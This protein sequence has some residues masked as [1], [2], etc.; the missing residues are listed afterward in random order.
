[1]SRF[2][3]RDDAGRALVGPVAALGLERPVL[4][5]LARG[6]V[7]VAAALAAGLGGAGRGTGGL[8][9]AVAVARKVTRPGAPEA[10]LGAVAAEGEPVWFSAALEQQGLSPDGLVDEVAAAREEVRRREAAWVTDRRDTD[11]RAVVGGR[12]VVLVDDGVA[13]G[14]TAHAALLALATRG[15]RRLVL[16]TPVIAAASRRRLAHEWGGEIVAAAAPE[17]FDAVASSYDDFHQLTD[18]DV[19]VALAPRG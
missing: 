6:G 9:I 16:A 19:T 4:V 18:D 13:T 1:M 15:P 8:E 5:G 11:W 7:P 2:A 3:D 14:V 10:G 17:D 12:D